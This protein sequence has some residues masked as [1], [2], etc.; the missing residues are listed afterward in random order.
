MYRLFRKRRQYNHAIDASNLEVELT[1][2]RASFWRRHKVLGWVAGIALAAFIVLVV[3]VSIVARRTEPFLR[4]RIVDALSEHFHARVELDSFHLRFGNGLRGEWG[5]WADG[6]GLRIWPPA[7]DAAP[8]W[9]GTP[10][11]RLDEFRFHAPLRYT[12]GMPVH[13]SE[14]R[15]NGLDIDLPPKSHAPHEAASPS[16]T[17]KPSNGKSS[18]VSFRVDRII[19]TGAHLVH[20]TDKPGK[21]P[22]E[23]DIQSLKLTDVTSHAAMSFEAQLTNPRPVGTIHTTGKFGPWLVD[24]PDESPVEGDYSFDHADLA[25]FKG[26]AGILTSTGHYQGTLRNINV[27]GETETPDFQL[28]DFGNAMAL[29]TQFHA[30]VD[31]TDGDTWL[32]PVNATLGHSHFVVQGQIVRVLAADADGP[33]HSIGHG[34]ALEVNVDQGHIE[35]FVRLASHE[36]TPMLTGSINVKASLHIPPG[37]EPVHQRMTLNGSFLLDQAQFTDPK[38]QDRIMDLSVRGQGRPGDV[39]ST[40]PVDIQA[41]IQ[42]DFQMAHGIITFPNLNFTVP[43][44]DVQLKGT[45]RL[46]GSALD[47]IGAANMQAS[48]SKMVGGWKGFLLKPA[49]RFFKKDGAGARI[50]IHIGGT[51]ASPKIGIDFKAMKAT[52]PERP[53]QKQ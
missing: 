10:L 25:S 45:Y 12:P 14:V 29:H 34:I 19:C 52:T 40:D 5:V 18:P 43:G 7:G 53:D 51:G 27:D 50:P 44:A 41:Q 46:Q 24:D 15:L 17:P 38:I 21:L 47:F 22:L 23:F 6:R 3:V 8:G 13:I 28:P 35:D 30:T 32:D 9:S 2:V 20:E 1:N 37:T 42:S 33:P 4:A 36:S 16:E 26:I 48:I 31:G 39:K 11:I 49:D